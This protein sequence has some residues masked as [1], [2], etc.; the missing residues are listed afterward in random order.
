MLSKFTL[1]IIGLAV[2]VFVWGLQYKISLYFPPHQVPQA[3]LLSKNEQPTRVERIVAGAT[4]L[5]GDTERIGFYAL[6]LSA[7]GLMHVVATS[8]NAAL[9]HRTPWLVALLAC[10]GAFLFRPP[11]VSALSC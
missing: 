3:K 2:S 8:R 5:V 7:L 1:V 11:P 9:E 6:A 4:K 10:L